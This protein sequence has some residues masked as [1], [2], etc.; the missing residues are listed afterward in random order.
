MR[1]YFW[2]LHL[3]ASQIY[4]AFLLFTFYYLL[5]KSLIR[6]LGM[7]LTEAQEKLTIY[8]LYSTYVME[9]YEA[10]KS[11][12]SSVP[13]DMERQT[14]IHF[15]DQNQIRTKPQKTLTHIIKQ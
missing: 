7:L 5:S 14:T 10:I 9:C 6:F 11:I 4:I 8:K 3:Y 12:K 1:V 13:I 15:F 2:T